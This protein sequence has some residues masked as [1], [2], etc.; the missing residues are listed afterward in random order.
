MP[1]DINETHDPKLESWVESANDPETDFPIQNLPLCV[2]DLEPG[3]QY[4]KR[5][6]GIVIGD[7]VLD[8][9]ESHERGFLQL[10]SDDSYSELV[11]SLSYPYL[12][13]DLSPHARLSL[14]R[15]L[16]RFLRVDSPDKPRSDSDKNRVL[17]PL[18]S[19]RLHSPVAARD[20]T[21][22][23]AS[24]HHAT[25]VGSMFRPDN[26][27]LPNYKHIPIGYHG[28][29][30]SIV[31]S[32][33][34]IRRPVGQQEPAETH[35]SESRATP[36][37][38]P[39]KLL[40]YELELGAIIGRGNEL[41]SH[42]PIG[43]AEDHIFGMCILND[44]SARDIQK[45]EY[46]PLG[47]FLAK[48]FASSVSP[49]I[50]TME[51]LAPFRT[52]AFERPAGDPRPLAYLDSEYNRSHGG[53]DITCEA[54]LASAAMRER[55]MA[56]VR[57]SKGSFRHMYWT[58]AQLVAHHTVNGCNLQPGDLLGSGTISGPTRDSR[59]CLLELT[60]DGDPWANPPKIV[61]GTQRTPIRLPT[62]EERKFLADGDEVIIR[63]YCERE[64]Y[65]RIGFGECR[66]V[67]EAARVV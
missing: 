56:P 34:P 24:L 45:W 36:A 48:N 20:Y 33:T 47:P 18:S 66:G 1:Y 44:W 22:F 41:G 60:W 38:G 12:E 53:I 64:G 43:E 51:A 32:G 50:V 31:P 14:R 28:R 3:F 40:D 61:P 57:L 46:Q 21:D 4:T 39:C 37:F 29:A 2:Y 17:F 5:R 49:Y 9:G 63:A 11:D 58:L 54:Y 55:G 13:L 15:A 19:V 59:G 62:G 65:R 52:P 26:P 35:G 23:Y 16:T 8:L 25:N 30:S 67:I 7:E 42:I 6:T 10:D 27:L